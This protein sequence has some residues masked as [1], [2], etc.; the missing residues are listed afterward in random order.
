MRKSSTCPKADHFGAALFHA[1]ATFGVSGSGSFGFKWLALIE[2]D[3]FV[4]VANL[5]RVLSTFSADSPLWLGPHGCDARYTGD[6]RE[7]PCVRWSYN[8][9]QKCKPARN[10]SIRYSVPCGGNDGAELLYTFGATIGDTH[11]GSSLCVFSRAFLTRSVPVPSG[12]LLDSQCHRCSPSMGDI[13]ASQCF[14]R[15][16][17]VGPTGIPVNLSLGHAQ[18]FIVT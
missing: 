17:T 4:N 18:L 10:A 7:P 15:Q 3:V 1:N 5:R 14:F 16:S 6:T 8:A 12:L 11:C 9:L 2:D 13:V